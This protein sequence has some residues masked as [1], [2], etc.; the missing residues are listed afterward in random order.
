VGG[1]RTTLDVVLAM[2]SAAEEDEG[3]TSPF[4]SAYCPSIC[5]C[6]NANACGFIPSPCTEK[7]KEI[8]FLSFILMEI[9]SKN[10]KDSILL[11]YSLLDIAINT[12][13][14]QSS[15][16]FQCGGRNDSIKAGEVGLKQKALFN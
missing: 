6:R 7:G 13:I 4:M 15:G 1:A 2:G 12:L 3:A 14:G 8:P 16:F 11:F 10:H 5:C 9:K